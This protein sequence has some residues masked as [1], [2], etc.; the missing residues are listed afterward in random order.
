LLTITYELGGVEDVPQIRLP[1][2]TC[3][4]VLGKL[5]FQ[6]WHLKKDFE[7]GYII[8]WNS[9][10]ET[11]IK[12]MNSNNTLNHSRTDLPRSRVILTANQ[13]RDIF[14]YKSANND[15]L[16]SLHATSILLA[17][18]YGVS[19]KAIRD[20]WNG[21]SWLDATFDL[22]DEKVR[23]ARKII[24]RPKGRRDSQPRVSHL[25][26]TKISQSGTSQPPFQP[27]VR[28]NIHP[29]SNF[30]SQEWGLKSHYS[31][32]Y[33]AHPSN[34]SHEESS[35]DPMSSACSFFGFSPKVGADDCL[36]SRF[37]FYPPST[38]LPP[39]QPTLLAPPLGGLIASLRLQLGL[40]HHPMLLGSAPST[41]PPFAIAATAA[42]KMNPLWAA[43][44]VSAPTTF[45]FHLR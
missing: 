24:G 33:S 1:V 45:P 8:R 21:R 35:S 10:V 20:I 18:K 42:A 7:P 22:W 16:L 14:S 27:T 2:V 31:S 40:L 34:I 13:A 32:V 29:E 25:C 28:R 17:H 23:P 12:G 15:K 30:G 26:N 4:T 36:S 38:A 19:S 39:L 5:T 11:S 41:I 37:L 6:V 3:K 44:A 9:K 43:A